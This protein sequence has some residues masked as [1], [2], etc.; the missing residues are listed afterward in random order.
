MSNPELALLIA[1]PIIAATLPLLAGLK[2]EAVGWP[3]A[4]LTAGV[5]LALAGSVVSR[6]VAEGRFVHNLGGYPRTYGIELVVD[7]FS[8][9]VISLIAVVTL[10]VVAYARRGGPRENAFYSAFLLLLGGLMGVGLTGDVFNM[11][12]FLEIV[13]LATYALVAADRSARAALASLKYLIVGTAGASLYLVGVGFLLVATGTLN[14]T[15]LAATI[16]ETVGYT[17]P[18][19]VASF[20]FVAVGLSVKAAIFPLHTWISDAYAESPDT[21]TAYISGLA[22]TLGA[23]ALARLVYAVY[24]P[25]FFE[26]VPL[27]GDALVA[28]ATVSIVAGSVLAVIQS[29]VKRMLAYSSVA[30]FGM[31]VAAFGLATEQ[32]LVGGIVHLVGHGLM[33][34]ALFLGVGV[35]ASA[36]GIR[37]VRQ[38][39][40][41]GY[42]SPVA[43]AAIAAL[44]LGLVGV[45]PSIGFLG[46]WYIAWGAI[47]AGAP[48]VAAVVLFSTLLTLLYVARLLETMYFQ[49]ADD[50][51]GAVTADGRGVR[52]L[53][54]GGSGDDDDERPV[55]FGMVFV[56]AALS[57]AAV[58]LGF[59]GPVFEAFLDP[60][61]EAVL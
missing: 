16:P 50:I 32:A 5:E 30:Q 11:F 24:T 40:N 56:V 2:F 18:L 37:T 3:I 41:L 7:E 12:V 4:A 59:A 26:A 38:Y 35:I 53:S 9:V 25:A 52:L 33:K 22:S 29:D 51:E 14:M 54:D 48:I 28:F 17:D 49:P 31:I 19:I 20:C 45:P 47:E 15:D 60:F 27:A 58:A 8:A 55:S 36:Y 61:L 42:R 43:V 46:K 10:V 44:L 23:Y 6:V 39:A 1:I 57:V 21:V 13:G 34:T